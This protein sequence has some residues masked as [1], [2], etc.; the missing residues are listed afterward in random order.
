MHGRAKRKLK[1]REAHLERAD[2]KR[3]MLSIQIDYV[4]SFVWLYRREGLE[5]ITLFCQYYCCY[6]YP[7]LTSLW[8]LSVVVV[9]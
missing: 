7:N 8:L 2:A 6:C 9:K 1:C 3:V 4:E 5:S